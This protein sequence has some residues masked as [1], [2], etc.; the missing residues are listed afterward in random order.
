MAIPMF[1]W[2]LLLPMSAPQTALP[3]CAQHKLSLV[4]DDDESDDDDNMAAPVPAPTADPIP[5]LTPGPGSP[6]ASPIR[7]RPGLSTEAKAG[8]AV[9]VILGAL[10]I[11]GDLLFICVRHR[12]RRRR[13]RLR[14]QQGSGLENMLAPSLTII[15]RRTDS[16][17]CPKLSPR[18]T[19][20]PSHTSTWAVLRR[21]MLCRR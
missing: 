17:I 9:D 15:Q 6:G 11:F 20:I 16:T 12:R 7:T 18:T 1:P 3:T 2:L 4:R 8:I 10:I 5:T 19:S 13:R 14:T 21:N